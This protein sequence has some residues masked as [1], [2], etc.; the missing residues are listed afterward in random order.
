MR[1]LKNYLNLEMTKGDTF[2]FGVKIYEL[3]QP[4]E[5]A[6]FICKSNFLDL[7]PKFTKSLNQGIT[8]ADSD[9]QGN[10]TYR[11][12]IAPDDTGALE[13]GKYYYAMNIEVNSDVFTILKGVLTLDYNVN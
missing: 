3:G 11:V 1:L 12:R 13:I 8:I 10:Y 4:L 6:E 5:V 2:S 9:A 7:T